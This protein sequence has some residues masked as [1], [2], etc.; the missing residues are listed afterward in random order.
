MDKINHDQFSISE[1]RWA[2]V[3]FLRLFMREGKEQMVERVL[4][5]NRC[6]SNVCAKLFH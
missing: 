3:E 4:H 6:M 5:A 2:T 1:N